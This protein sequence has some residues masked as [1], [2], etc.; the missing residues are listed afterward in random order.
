VSAD[1]SFLEKYKSASAR[2]RSLLCVGLDPNPNHLP[3]SL[4]GR[5]DGIS[6]FLTDI[7]SATSDLVCAYKPNFAFFGALGESGFADL[8]GLIRNSPGDIPT[9]LD[10]KAGDIGN[11]ARRYAAMA[12]ET[13]GADATTVNPLMGSDAVLPFLE[14]KG[15]CAFLLCLTSNPGS[16]DFQRLETG[17]RTLY[18][19]IAARAVEWS[20]SGDCGLVVG[21]THPGELGGIRALAPGLPF[22]VP[23][24]GAQGGNA[25]EVVRTGADADGGGLLINA[26]RAV[27]YASSG[28][29]YAEA[30]RQQAERLRS[31]FE[32]ARASTPA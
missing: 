20:E 24:V 22:L 31:T 14:Y 15:S 26:S 17:D 9:I 13:L 6:R 21:A 29:D 27:L 1:T 23:G 2:N 7:V 4:K 25:E 11:T 32:A 10:F 8:A 28:S 18:E 30:A 3:D 5:P 16:A 12:Y 19:A